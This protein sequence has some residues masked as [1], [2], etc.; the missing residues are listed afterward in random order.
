MAALFALESGEGEDLWV[1]LIG[2]GV[3]GIGL[4]LSQ[5]GLQT[6]VLES[7]TSDQSGSASGVFS[8]SRYIGSIAGSSALPMLYASGDDMAGFMRVLS[9]VVIAA[10]ASTGA[11][12]WL[13]HRPSPD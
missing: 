3:A 1:L 13:Q 4:G 11:S 9:V 6:G 7:V 2:L 12:L 5:A 10:L 8:T